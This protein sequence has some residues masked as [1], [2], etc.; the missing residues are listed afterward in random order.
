MPAV[1][2]KKRKKSDIVFPIPN[3][4]GGEN[5]IKLTTRERVIGEG[6]ERR[7]NREKE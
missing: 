5:N 1:S 3:R 4:E 2:R 6:G 7:L